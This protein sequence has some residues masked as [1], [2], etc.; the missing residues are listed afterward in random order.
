[1]SNTV[2]YNEDGLWSDANIQ[3][4]RRWRRQ[5]FMLEQMEYGIQDP[6]TVAAAQ[7]LRAQIKNELATPRPCIA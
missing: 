1:M 5:Y 6:E 4:R 7:A 3:S 2:E